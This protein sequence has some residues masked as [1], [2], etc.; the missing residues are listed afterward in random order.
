MGHSV[1]HRTEKDHRAHWSDIAGRF[2]EEMECIAAFIALETAEVLA[3]AKPATLLNIPNKR[4]ECGQNLH[5]LWKRYGHEILADSPL[6]S[7]VLADND[8]SV[9]LL[10]YR[11]EEFEHHLARRDVRALLLRAGYPASASPSEILLQLATRLKGGRFPH[12]IG[13]I[14]GYPAK[15]VAAFMGW[16]NLPFACQGPWKMYG[17]PSESLRLVERFRCC[18]ARMAEHLNIAA[19]ALSCLGVQKTASATSF[20]H[21]IDNNNHF[22]WA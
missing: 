20:C 8:A 2:P 11:P 4:R 10:F 1:R 6:V 13:L 5:T 21:L 7:Y 16:I 18:R 9:S 3:G 15:D 12:E 17:N 22:P 14:L 19:S